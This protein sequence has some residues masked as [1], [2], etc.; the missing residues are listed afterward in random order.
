MQWISWLARSWNPPWSQCSESRFQT[1]SARRW[2]RVRPKSRRAVLRVG[3]RVAIGVGRASDCGVVHLNSLVM[4]DARPLPK[5][6]VNLKLRRAPG[7]SPLRS[8]PSQP[9]G[10]RRSDVGCRLRSLP[11]RA[12][13]PIATRS[14]SRATRKRRRD[15]PCS[16]H[17]SGPQGISITG[18]SS[19]TQK[20]E[21]R[22]PNIRVRTRL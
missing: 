13:P 21:C 1:P 20:C 11:S 12:G 18:Q 19:S 6:A 4:H 10:K 3:D 16:R 5:E 15:F 22:R 7:R 9:G 2:A 8:P 14:D 17:G